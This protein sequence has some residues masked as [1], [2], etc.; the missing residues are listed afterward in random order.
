M[1]INLFLNFTHHPPNI[2]EIFFKK[3]LTIIKIK[4]KFIAQRLGFRIVTV[5]CAFLEFSLIENQVASKLPK[6]PNIFFPF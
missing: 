1:Q 2:T 5:W 4:Q 3:L 6:F